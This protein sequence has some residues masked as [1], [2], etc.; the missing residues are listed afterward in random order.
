MAR[1]ILG[2]FGPESAQRKAPGARHGGIMAVRDVHNYQHPQ[3]PTNIGDGHSPGLHGTN[4]GH[5]QCCYADIEGGHP[6]ISHEK[7][8]Y[9]SQK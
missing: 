6:G 7:H 1:D 9:G 3:G 5:D 8:P 2:E 4:H